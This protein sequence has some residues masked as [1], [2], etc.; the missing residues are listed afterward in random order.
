MHEND[1]E[2]LDP[3]EAAALLDQT[4]R[5]AQRQFDLRQPPFILVAAGVELFAYGVVWLSVRHQDPYVGPAGWALA[6]L[7]AMIAV[8]IAIVAV[9]RR[10]AYAGIGGQALRERNTTGWV[11]LIVWGSA[12]VFQGALHHAGASDA[13]VYG[14]FPAT[15][16]VIIV[17]GA[18]AA[19]MSAKEQ[20]LTL[21]F[22]LA[23]VALALVASFFG[24]IAVW[25]VMAIGACSLLLA[26][27]AALAWGPWRA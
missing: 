21:Y 22:A 14:I 16:P 17:G 3:R 18:A 15:A 5:E 12:F 20:P 2:Q 11:F 10:R 27:A 7:Y 25:G 26:Y 19:Y 13:I 4:T 24:P 8:W 23:A 6:V 1:T 9:A